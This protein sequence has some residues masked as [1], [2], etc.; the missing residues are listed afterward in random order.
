VV[1][2]WFQ[3]KRFFKQQKS[4]IE[5]EE[6]TNLEHPVF[7]GQI[8]A[9]MLGAVAHP[10]F[11]LYSQQEVRSLLPSTSLLPYFYF[12]TSTFTSL[13]LLLLLRSTSW[14]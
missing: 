12:L 7:A 9:E 6:I 2:D 1:T 13:L 11:Y 8:F 4:K 5:E 10:E 3:A 14:S